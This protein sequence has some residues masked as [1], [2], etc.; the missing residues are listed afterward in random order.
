M[1]GPTRKNTPT[2][3][4]SFIVQKFLLKKLEKENPYTILLDNKQSIVDGYWKAINNNSADDLLSYDCIEQT[5]YEKE[6][7]TKVNYLIDNSTAESADQSYSGSIFGAY[8]YDVAQYVENVRAYEEQTYGGY[9]EEFYSFQQKYILS[10]LSQDGTNRDLLVFDNKGLVSYI[11]ISDVDKIYDTKLIDNSLSNDD[12]ELLNLLNSIK[13]NQQGAIYN[14][15]DFDIESLVVPEIYRNVAF[16]EL[17]LDKLS[18][19]NNLKEIIVSN[20]IRY[21]T[22]DGVLY[23][24][25]GSKLLFYPK[26]KEDTTF[27]IPEDVTSIRSNSISNAN[28]ETINVSSNVG[29]IEENAFKEC[30]LFWKRNQRNSYVFRKRI[31]N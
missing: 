8:I 21:K 18:L 25:S 20:G 26:A 3:L 9:T 14:L 10:Y 28:L 1:I 13:Y 6:D 31:K 16:A 22:I 12:V 5:G 24:K 17:D 7:D 15:N 27:D 23:N 29:N 30:G 11:N 4:N 19:C 2:A